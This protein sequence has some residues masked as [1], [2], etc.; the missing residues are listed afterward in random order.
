[1]NEIGRKP[2]HTVTE[3]AS[4]RQ[5]QENPKTRPTIMER[6]VEGK[7]ESECAWKSFVAHC[8][9]STSIAILRA[10]EILCREFCV[11]GDVTFLFGASFEWACAFFC[12]IIRVYYSVFCN[13]S[14]APK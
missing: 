2:A 7:G 6:A 8:N 14:C 12:G 9:S 4:A 1:M 11:V 3:L 10:S 13:A 5:H